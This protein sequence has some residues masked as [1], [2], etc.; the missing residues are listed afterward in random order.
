MYDD[1]KNAKATSA[2]Y[3][4][5]GFGHYSKNSEF[6]PGFLGN[7]TYCNLESK[8]DFD[9]LIRRLQAEHRRRNPRAGVFISYA[10]DDEPEWID[11]LLR[12]LVSI[13]RSGITVWTDRDIKPG[14]RWHE[15]IQSALARAKVA[16]LLVSQKF[17]SS[18][19]IS[20][21]ELPNFLQ[22][23]AA[24]GLT[25]FWIPIKPSGYEGTEIAD[26]QAAHPPSQ[27]LSSLR[28]AKRDAAFVSIAKRLAEALGE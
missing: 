10:H 24:D 15:E 6:I 21:Q 23:A 14:A 7:A 3:V 16:V 8:D 13:V 22:A 28:G 12:H 26:F 9:G 18:Q 4:P 19:Y 20:N 27:P 1:W 25:I 2:K 11:T 17:L 5:V